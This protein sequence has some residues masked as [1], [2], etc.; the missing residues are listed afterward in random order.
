MAEDEVFIG[1]LLFLLRIIL[2]AGADIFSASIEMQVDQR[3]RSGAFGRPLNLGMQV[4][5]L[6]AC[7]HPNTKVG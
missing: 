2:R 6:L 5:I 7:S 1:Q 4:I 3:Q